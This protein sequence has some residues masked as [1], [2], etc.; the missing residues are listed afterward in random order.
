[1]KLRTLLAALCCL[2][3]GLSSRPGLSPGLGLTPAH[4]Q[5]SPEY[6]R[7]VRPILM[8]A[9]LTCHGPDSASRKADLRLDQR[10]AAVDMGAIVP[11][12]PAESAM[13]QRILSD[14]PEQIMPPPAMKKT[15]SEKQKQILADWIQGGAVYQKHWSLIA[16]VRPQVPEVPEEL[17]GQYA[18]WPVNPIDNFVLSGL[19]KEKLTPAPRA[20]RHTLARRVSLDIIGLPP[21]PELLE[22]FVTDPAPDSVALEKLVDQLL[23]SPHWGEHRGRYWLDYAR[24]ADTH[25]IHFDNFREMWSYRDWVIGAF[26]QNMP[27]DQ[28]TIENLAGDL[29]PGATLDQQIASGFNRCNMTTN[30]G[31]I[32]DEEYAV[33]YTRD[34]TEAVSQVWMGLT[35]GCAVCHSHKFDPLSQQEFY[36]MAA[37]FNNTTQKVRDGNIKDP[38][39]IV[40]VPA[41]SDR[42][43]WSEMPGLIAA[44]KQSQDQR[45]LDS[46]PTFDSWL[47]TAL[48]ESLGDSVS[49]EALS[50]QVL[51]DEGEGRKIRATVD[52]QPAELEL[53]ESAQW[54]DGPGGKAIAVQGAACEIPGFGDFEKTDAF[55]C[56]A[57]VH[58]P[59]NDSS[60]PICARMDNA[61]AHRGWDFWMQQRRIGMHL[62]NAWPDKALKVVCREQI[63][64]NQ[65]VHVAV[66]YDGSS[67][68]SGLKIYVGGA[69]QEVN[70]ENDRLDDSTIR[71]EVP[72]R[73]GQRSGAD[74]FSGGLQDLRVYR[75]VLTAAEVDSLAK[76]S[77]YE[78]VLAKADDQRT[79]EEKDEL[80]GYWL[81]RFDD[82][83]KTL[84]SQLSA[85]QKEEADI[86]AR[87]TIAHVM[88]EKS[89]PATAW[90]LYRGEYDQRREQVFPDTPEALPAF[91]DSLPKNR[92][93]FAQ[94]LLLPDHP[95]TARVTVN[96]YWQEVF[97]TGLVRTAGDF[98]VSGELPSNQELLDWLAVDFRESGWDVKRLI[99][100][101]VM[102]S[103]YQQSAQVTPEKLD[104]DPTNRLLSRGPRFRMD[105]EMVRDYALT[106]SGLLVPKLGGPSVRPYQPEGVWEAIAMN[107]SNTRSY[108]RDSGE[109]LYR[110]S[111]YTFVK[112]MAPPASMDIFNAPNRELCVVRRDRTNTPLQA[113]VTLNDEQFI[114]AARNLAQRLMKHST[115]VDERL[116]QLSERVLCREFRAQ[117]R[118]VVEQSLQQLL[119]FYTEHPDEAT[120]LIRVGESV[121]DAALSP[122]E[123][124]A[125][126]ML[127]NE[128]LN[129]DEVLNK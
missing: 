75:R 115:T 32:I 44:A 120:Q 84:T 92:L 77:R 50:L 11:G 8:D 45:K 82:S 85:L 37:F 29:L 72:F 23:K 127:C 90:I 111:M 116:N 123:L 80:Y 95:L 66:S 33:L 4:G 113:L 81:T 118:P 60:G 27:W 5:E 126:T 7:D 63:P 64:A 93:G 62:I 98:G 108:T 42:D 40:V 91:P 71:T 73:I 19:A 47:S 22:S 104:A 86:K 94:W 16:P 18:Q 88:H 107:V 48:P 112:R 74:A 17:K 28:F 9:C 56:S 3:S 24:Y 2:L 83:W 99:K 105:A 110:R 125:W 52:N 106:V 15:L 46:R 119:A 58:L 57:W 121:A 14:D 103:T 70:I 87:G 55:T 43:R 1:M 21:E 20:D 129:L 68:S 101:I 67:R 100:M 117:E 79:A 6:N 59:A 31:G 34:R 97:G 114:E 109:S 122:A 102:S 38:P 30:E 36:E 78:R 53:N 10:D 69:A 89:E 25:G 26:N 41:A 49:A 65:W 61:N 39:P 76:L 51:L 128:I 96:R 54:R 124:A 13:I 12:K 35:S